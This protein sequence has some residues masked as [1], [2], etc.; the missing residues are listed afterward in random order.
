[1]EKKHFCTVV[2][3]IIKSKKKNVKKHYTIIQQGRIKLVHKI[4][5]KSAMIS[6]GSCDT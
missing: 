5:T 1:M 4:N 6:E 3:K 2:H